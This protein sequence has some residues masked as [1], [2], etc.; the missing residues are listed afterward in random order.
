MFRH[1]DGLLATKAIFELSGDH[2]GVS[3]DSATSRAAPPAIAIAQM[4]FTRGP[5]GFSLREAVNASHFPS[6]EIC[7]SPSFAVEPVGYFTAGRPTGM[8]ACSIPT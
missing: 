1:L 6:G 2:L 4:P 7:G 3:A 8:S 5:L